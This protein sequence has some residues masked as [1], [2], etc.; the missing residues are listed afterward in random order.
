[1]SVTYTIS[2]PPHVINFTTFTSSILSCSP[3]TYTATDGLLASLNPLIY[4]FNP[5]A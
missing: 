2:D 1:M 5:I 3:I 4:T